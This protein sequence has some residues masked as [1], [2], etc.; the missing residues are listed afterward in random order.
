MLDAAKDFP[1]QAAILS[2]MVGNVLLL[3]AALAVAC[4]FSSS[5]TT[6]KWYLIAV[7][8]ADY[9]HIYSCYVGLGPDVFW[10]ISQWNDMIVGNVGASLV[11]NVVR[12]FTLLGVFGRLGQASRTTGSGKKRN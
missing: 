7:A 8:F 5:A 1:P 10:D 11:L 9:G 3:L 4:C 6:A 12:W 2:L